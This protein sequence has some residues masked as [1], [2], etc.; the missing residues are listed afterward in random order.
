MELV[1]P[2]APPLVDRTRYSHHAPARLRIAANIFSLARCYSAVCLLRP[3]RSA[4]G[5]TQAGCGVRLDVRLLQRT[6]T[7]E[8]ISSSIEPP[9]LLSGANY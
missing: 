2:F 4:E 9:L 1:P 8:T 3:L 6:S 5:T 7:H